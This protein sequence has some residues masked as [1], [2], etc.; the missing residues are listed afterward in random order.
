VMADGLMALGVHATPTADGIVI[1]G[2]PLG[3]GDVE[4]HDDHRI[5]MAFSVAG[6]RARAA[7]RIHNCNNVATSFPNFVE[8]ANRVGF[9]LVVSP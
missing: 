5:S 3:G 9:G 1:E 8:L 2:G 6:L 7:V 4:S